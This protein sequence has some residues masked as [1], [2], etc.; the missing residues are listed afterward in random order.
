MDNPN[1]VV[2]HVQDKKDNLLI[3]QKKRGIFEVI[4]ER[5]WLG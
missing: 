2:G 4:K 5:S 1:L 3:F